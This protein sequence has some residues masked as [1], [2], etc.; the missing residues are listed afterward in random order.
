MIHVHLNID[1][2]VY[3]Y[4]INIQGFVNEKTCNE[5]KKPSSYTFPNQNE[6]ESIARLN[7]EGIES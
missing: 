3:G 7:D 6:R 5:K 4:T 1:T 2:A